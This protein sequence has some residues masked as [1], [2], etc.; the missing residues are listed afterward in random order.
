MSRTVQHNANLMQGAA[1]G[2]DI[3]PG[4][5]SRLCHG[6]SCLAW[7]LSQP[8]VC[9]LVKVRSDNSEINAVSLK[10]RYRKTSNKRTTTAFCILEIVE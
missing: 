7:V 8:Q 10:M 9:R 2:Y 5:E 3:A 6:S 1:P 4:F